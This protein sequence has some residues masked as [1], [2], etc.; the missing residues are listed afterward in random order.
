MPT[1]REPSVT[2]GAV[3]AFVTAALA[4]L[5][6]FGLGLDAEQQAAI[7]GFTAV[8]VPLVAALLIRPKVTPLVDPVGEAGFPL[9]PLTETPDSFPDGAG[10]HRAP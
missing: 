4:L 3:V 1:T 10:E 7:L 5:V 2:V 9:V 6:S 8:A